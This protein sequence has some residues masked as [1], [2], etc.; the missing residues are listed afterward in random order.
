ML[1]QTLSVIILIGSSQVLALS[2]QE[3]TKAIGDDPSF[4]H[5]LARCVLVTSTSNTP[6]DIVGGDQNDTEYRT[7][8]KYVHDEIIFRYMKGHGVKRIEAYKNDNFIAATYTSSK[9]SHLSLDLGDIEAGC[10]GY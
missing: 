7:V 5:S 6:F 8:E 10:R 9:K 2:T 4:K 1:K 3:N